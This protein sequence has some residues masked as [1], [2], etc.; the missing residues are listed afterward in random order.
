[1]PL[2]LLMMMLA[3]AERG[4]ALSLS[5]SWLV[6]LSFFL[7]L[8][9]VYN[10]AKSATLSST[11]RGLVRVASPLPML[12]VR[13]LVYLQGRILTTFLFAEKVPF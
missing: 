5:I 9:R 2:L 1:M 6:F 11:T 12:C 4:P 10:S 7:F 13:V 8:W 3:G